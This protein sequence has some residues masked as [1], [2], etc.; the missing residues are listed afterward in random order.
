MIEQS[1]EF[2]G[3]RKLHC[4]NKFIATKI[5]RAKWQ[6]RWKGFLFVC[7]FSYRP[8]AI[9]KVVTFLVT[10]YETNWILELSLKSKWNIVKIQ[11]ISWTLGCMLLYFGNLTK[12]TEPTIYL[13]RYTQTAS[14]KHF[15][16]VTLL[17]QIFILFKPQSQKIQ[18]REKCNFSMFRESNHNKTSNLDLRNI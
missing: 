9:S 10:K 7:L 2:I 5:W 8:N 17:I 14:F 6:L 11:F 13:T 12:K 3:T 1:R 16:V 18:L 15:L 4:T